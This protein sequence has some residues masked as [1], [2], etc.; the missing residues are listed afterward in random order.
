MLSAESIP[1][2]HPEISNLNNSLTQMQ[3]QMQQM[4]QAYNQNLQQAQQATINQLFDEFEADKMNYPHFGS[5]YQ[6]M[7]GLVGQVRAE[8]PELNHRQVLQKAYQDAVWLNPDVRGKMLNSQQRSAT[9][10]QQQQKAANAASASVRGAP[11]G[12]MPLKANAKV[13]DKV[14]DQLSQLWDQ[15]L[16]GNA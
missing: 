1:Q 14:H 2:Q 12:A 16:E 9:V 3:Q 5:V 15:M 4:Q 7:I 11:N 13:P 6:Q 8:N 10:T